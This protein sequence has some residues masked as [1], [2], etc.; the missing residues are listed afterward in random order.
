MSVRIVTDSTCD[1]P[2]SY[3][4][5]HNISVLP[6]PVHMGGQ[7]YIVGP[8]KGAPGVIT[9]DE[10]YGRIAAGETA[11]TAQIPIA[12]YEQAFR[13]ILA[14]GDDILYLCLSSGLTGT[15]NSARLAIETIGNDYPGRRVRLV[16]TLSASLGEGMA[17]DLAVQKREQGCVSPDELADYVEANKQRIKHWF[18]VDD[19]HYLAR[20]GRLSGS[21]AFVGSLLSVK[22][23]MDVS[24]VGKL[25]PREKVQGR[26]RALK[27][28]AEK[29]S[30]S[31]NCSKRAHIAHSGCEEDALYLKKLM[32]ERGVQVDWI[33]SLTPVIVSHAGLGVIALFFLCDTPRN[34]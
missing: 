18:T 6:F 10:F 25:V 26:K 33:E 15:L 32:E 4:R 14:A 8:A 19:L 30:L 20:G 12:T 16:D 9:I 31:E 17:V 34:P 3:I 13:E 7:E 29:Y 27:A 28:I 24:E 1:L 11:T 5:E 21:A 22:P 2:I 23:I